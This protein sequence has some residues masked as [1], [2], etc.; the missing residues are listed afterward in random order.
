MPRIALERGADFHAAPVASAL[1]SQLILNASRESGGHIA[2]EFVDVI[3]PEIEARI[4]NRAAISLSVARV[5][6][7]LGRTDDGP[8][9][10][11]RV[12]TGV[13]RALGCTLAPTGEG[14]YAVTLPSWRLDL[15][16]EIDLVEE[17]A[18]VYGY[19]RFANTLPTFSGTVIE[20]PH[21]PKQSAV[22]SLLLAAGYHEAISSTFCSA[23]DADTFAPQ[24]GISVAMGNPLS[25]EAGML[26]PSLVPGMLTMLTN[27]LNRNV[28]DVRLFE[29]GTVFTGSAER[30]DE[31]PSVTFGA[32]GQLREGLLASRTVDFYDLKGLVESLV[33]CFAHRSVYYDAFPPE[34]GL[35]PRWL[36]PGRAARCVVDGSTIGYFGELHPEEVARRKLRQPVFIGEVYLERLFGQSLRQPAARELSRYQAVH[37]DF[38]LVFPDT[39]HWDAVHS[40]LGAL[41]IAE[42][43]TYRPAEIFRDAKGNAVPAGHYSML[44]ATTFQAPER[45]LR[46]EELHDW[47]GRIVAA[48]EGLGGKLR[49]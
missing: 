40:A 3:I 18:R 25:E 7:L 19:N 32:T 49:G 44:V 10:T 13:L 37:R 33:A 28:D 39:V 21:A 5:A 22:R 14:R 15:E 45:T 17:V 31:A 42:L 29:M 43:Q 6:H 26:R 1:L 27:N 2:G 9:I 36:H 24:P 30:V 46:D 20:Q 35:F 12:V 38:S 16:R 47:S 48:L 23:T 41:S 34:S 4:A 11:D 8:G